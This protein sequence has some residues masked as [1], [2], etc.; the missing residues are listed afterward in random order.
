MDA[1]KRKIKGRA[2]RQKIYGDRTPV[3]PEFFGCMASKALP[4]GYGTAASYGT[5]KLLEK[6][7]ERIGMEGVKKAGPIGTVGTVLGAGIGCSIEIR[8]Q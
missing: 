2:T 3:I 8:N 5:E 6:L 1:V 7:L 4:I